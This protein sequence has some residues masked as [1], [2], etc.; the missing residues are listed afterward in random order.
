MAK[1]LRLDLQVRVLGTKSSAHES[2]EKE[3]T[4]KLFAHQVIDTQAVFKN[5]AYALWSEM[6]TG[7]SAIVVHA[8]CALSQI[9]A[10]NTV[11][12]VAPASVRCVWL[13][14]EIG[15]IRKHSILP[16]SVFEFHAKVKRAWET[17]TTGLTWIVTNYEFLRNEKHLTDL[18]LRLKDRK[19]MLVCDESSYIKSRTAAQTKAVMKLREHCDRCVILNGT[20]ITQS[21]LDLWSQCNVLSLDIL[22]KRFKSFYNFRAHYCEMRM[23][24]ARGHRFQ[25]VVAYKRLDHLAKIIAP[26]GVRRLKSECLDLPPKLYTAR[27]VALTQESWKRYQEL[28]KDAVIAL[29]NGNLQLEPNAA[30]RIMRLAQLTSG[31]LGS[32]GRLVTV[33]GIEMVAVPD[34]PQIQ[35][36]SS[37]KLD[38]IVK[39]LT[40]ECTAKAVIVWTRWR[41]ERERLYERLCKFGMQFNIFQLYGG[42]SKKNREFAVRSFSSEANVSRGILLAQPHAG[43]HGLNLIAATEEWF[44]SNDFSLGIRLQ[45]EARAHRPGQKSSLLIGDVLATGPKGEKTIDHTTVQALRSKQNIAD[46]TTARWRKELS[47]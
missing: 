5:G 13:D 40:E 25:K 17:G 26:Y 34:G 2:T 6:G 27:E 30:V 8:A 33:A 9:E 44:L 19:V 31:I 29:G 45:A 36:V 20:P 21:P 15:E 35:D 23:D 16:A 14:F 42:Q 4:I 43:G 32:I 46:F 24:F 37:E 41:R 12:V 10:I 11:V 22:Q 47:E 38:W 39:Y 7:K 18:I 3:M 28:K 1:V